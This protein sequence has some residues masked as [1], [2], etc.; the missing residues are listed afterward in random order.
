M[1]AYLSCHLLFN[2][3]S[4]LDRHGNKLLDLAL[5]FHDTIKPHLSLAEIVL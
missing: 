5:F 1:E 2:S 4:L 3:V